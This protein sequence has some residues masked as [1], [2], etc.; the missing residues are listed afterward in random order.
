MQDCGG[1]ETVGVGMLIT[2]AVAIFFSCSGA[3]RFS[4]YEFVPFLSFK[5]KGL[6]VRDQK[7]LLTTDP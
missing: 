4:V 5:P 1:A 2:S 7:Y 6:G 3:T